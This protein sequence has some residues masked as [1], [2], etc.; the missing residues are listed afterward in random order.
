MEFMDNFQAQSYVPWYPC[1]LEQLLQEC[2]PDDWRG[3]E[4]FMD[5]V[6]AAAHTATSEDD[7]HVRSNLLRLAQA[8]LNADD[9]TASQSFSGRPVKEGTPLGYPSARTLYLFRGAAMEII[10]AY[11]ESGLVTFPGAAPLSAD[12]RTITVH[13]G[14]YHD[15]PNPTRWLM[16]VLHA[17]QG[18]DL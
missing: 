18:A 9:W 3:G 8:R 16:R 1:T 10:G 15:T 11:A 4:L 13:A 17:P 14:I 2:D 12:D 5:A 7:G 6:R